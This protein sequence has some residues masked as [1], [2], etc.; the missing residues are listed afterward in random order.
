MCAFLFVVL[1][2][3]SDDDMLARRRSQAGGRSR[4]I[5]QRMRP[6]VI[7]ATELDRQMPR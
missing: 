2:T 4:G 7:L 5:I 6:A 1:A 3:I